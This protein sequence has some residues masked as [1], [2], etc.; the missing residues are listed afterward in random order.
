MSHIATFYHKNRVQPYNFTPSYGSSHLFATAML[1]ATT[2]RHFRIPMIN[3]QIKADYFYVNLY[4]FDTL[5]MIFYL[6]LSDYNTTQSTSFLDIM[7]EHKTLHLI[8]DTGIQF[9]TNEVEFNPSEPLPLKS[10]RMLRY[11]FVENVDPFDG[12][13]SF[14]LLYN[15]VD[16]NCWIPVRQ[17]RN[18]GCISL[19][20]NGTE[21]LDETGVP[22]MREDA[23][24]E[25]AG[26]VCRR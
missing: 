18:E 13:I 19:H 26:I 15:H 7:D 25:P 24:T 5:L 2:F 6:S 12:H 1:S 22:R 4:E 3:F 9:I 20:Q 8:A 16:K 17:L 11:S 21:D 14:D 10:G 23:S